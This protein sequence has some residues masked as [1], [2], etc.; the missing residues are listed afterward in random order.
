MTDPSGGRCPFKSR[1]PSSSYT[2]GHLQR[3]MDGH[4]EDEQAYHAGPQHLR[5]TQPLPICMP[6]FSF[7]LCAYPASQYPIRAQ[8]WPLPSHVLKPQQVRKSE[9][10]KFQDGRVDLSAATAAAGSIMFVLQCASCSAARLLERRSERQKERKRAGGGEGWPAMTG[11]PRR[12]RRPGC[13]FPTCNLRAVNLT[14][15]HIDTSIIV[16]EGGV[17]GGVGGLFIS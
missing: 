3:Q 15:R 14:S 8:L 5:F 6:Q 12:S 13:R 7:F 9:T 16:M 11:M 4:A 1:V 10:Q 2:R 17:G